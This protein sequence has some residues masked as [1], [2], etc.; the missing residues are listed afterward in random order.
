MLSALPFQPTSLLIASV[1]SPILGALSKYRRSA[2]LAAFRVRNATGGTHR[3]RGGGNRLRHIC[4]DSLELSLS[5][6]W[7]ED[8]S[9]RSGLPACIARPN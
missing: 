9:L 1:L 4:L 5:F 6:G 7:R 3:S 2:L 8:P